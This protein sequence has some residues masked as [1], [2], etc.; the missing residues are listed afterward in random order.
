MSFWETVLSTAIAMIAATMVTLGIT[1]WR[2]KRNKSKEEKL[3]VFRTLMATRADPWN[4]SH[5]SALNLI[6]LAFYDEKLVRDSWKEYLDHLNTTRPEDSASGIVWDQRRVDLFVSLLAAMSGG[7]GF[8][9]DRVHIKNQGYYPNKYWKQELSQL[10][11]QQIFEH[12][13]N[14]LLPLSSVQGKQNDSDAV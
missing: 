11:Q 3:F 13:A 12:L 8:D 9:F 4:A 7:L 14:Q 5:I 2:D 6:D 1:W 10:H